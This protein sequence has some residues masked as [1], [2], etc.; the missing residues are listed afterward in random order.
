MT[1]TVKQLNSNKGTSKS[2]PPC[3]GTQS[4]TNLDDD[5]DQMAD[6]DVDVSLLYQ[7]IRKLTECIKEVMHN[8]GAI[9]SMQTSIATP[10]R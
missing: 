8:T 3:K 7:E 10:S 4:T 9:P 5:A 2:V 6:P 1:T